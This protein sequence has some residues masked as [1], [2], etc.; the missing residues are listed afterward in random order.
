MAKLAD[1]AALAGVSV[2]TVSRVINN[3]GSLS[4]KTK[5]KVFSAMQELNYA[6]NSLARSLQGKSAKLI[7]LIFPG[8]SNPFF[9]E[10]VQNLENQL[11]EKGYRVI[12][13]N[14]V[15]NAEKEREY[16]RML[17]A[18]QVDGIITGTHNMGIAEYEKISAPLISFDRNLGDTIPIVSSD[19]FMGGKMATKSLVTTGAKKVWAITGAN[20]P[21]SPTR[22]RLN[23]YT[24]VMAQNGLPEHVI[25]LPFGTEPELKWTAIKTALSN[26]VPDGVFATDDLTAMM[27]LQ[28]ARE[29]N[30]DVPDQMRVVGYN[31]TTIVQSTF[32]GLATI[33]QPI[34]AM[35]TLMVDLL[36]Q[37]IEAPDVKLDPRYVVPVKLHAA[38]TL[39][40]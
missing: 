13:C 5:K 26:D 6:P 31:G 7:G 11:F 18:N 2:T 40:G 15:N 35:S 1:V 33:V 28:I 30:I 36:M 32:P 37:R 9:G 27:V 8:V 22:D 19:N 38:G 25:K 39:M 17:L 29:L 23:G 34:E 3:Y 4:E 16:V 12:L 20:E 14:S 10:L 24:E 21:K